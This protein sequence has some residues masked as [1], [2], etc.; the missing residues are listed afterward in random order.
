MRLLPLM[1]AIF[2]HVPNSHCTGHLPM[3]PH[4]GRA[5][6]VGTSGLLATESGHNNITNDLIKGV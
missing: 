1:N 5:A 3:G 4:W 2:A 6:A